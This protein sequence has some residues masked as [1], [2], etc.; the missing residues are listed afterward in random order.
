MYIIELL[1][2]GT[3]YQIVEL[4]QART[5]VIQG[6]GVAERKRWAWWLLP[7]EDLLMAVSSD[8]FTLISQIQALI[9]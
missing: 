7:S 4:I 9:Y 3:N 2:A 5:V 1:I 6:V 8:K